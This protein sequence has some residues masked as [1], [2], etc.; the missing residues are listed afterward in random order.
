MRAVLVLALFSMLVAAPARAAML[1]VQL[2]LE[3]VFDTHPIAL[4]GAGLATVNSSGGGVHLTRVELGAGVISGATLVSI[5]DPAT[6]AITGLQLD[7][8]NAAGTIAQTV[9]GSLTGALGLPGIL[10]FCVFGSGGCNGALGN[11]SVP[12]TPVGQGGSATVM[13]PANVSVYGAPWTTG[14]ASIGA[15]TMMGFAHGPASGTSSTAQAGGTIQLVTPSYIRSNADQGL[16]LPVFVFL[17]LQFVPEPGTALLLAGGI[18]AL[19][20]MGRRK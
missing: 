16:P 8:T 12:L 19:G 7:V 10:K 13:G 3:V 20:T 9:G 6:P 14:T 11:I 15:I 18:V 5:A 2:T 1:P 17:T 4:S